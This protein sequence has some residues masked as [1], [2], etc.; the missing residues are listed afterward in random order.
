MYCDRDIVVAVLVI[1]LSMLTFL[2]DVLKK[3][4][5]CKSCMVKRG[6]A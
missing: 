1:N 3:S 2:Q 6:R 4:C 5:I